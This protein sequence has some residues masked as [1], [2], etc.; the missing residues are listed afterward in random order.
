MTDGSHVIPVS[1]GQ[2]DQDKRR[3]GENVR[4]LRA[5][6]GLSQVELAEAMV[7]K[8]Q[9]HWR[10]TT[11]SRVERGIQS[12]DFEEWVA[13]EEI[14]GPGILRGTETAHNLSV[15]AGR[16]RNTILIHRLSQV[17]AMLADSMERTRATL[18][19]VAALRGALQGKPDLGR[20]VELVEVLPTDEA[21]STKEPSHEQRQETP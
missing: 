10:Q 5:S 11:V 16:L 17:E 12:V 7:E 19:E 1:R 21:M 2:S 18:E 14:L 20:E 6:A 13:L 9:T 8:G 15:S 3:V 4:D